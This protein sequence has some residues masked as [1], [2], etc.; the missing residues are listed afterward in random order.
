[1]QRPSRS[2][3][4]H[5][6]AG[7]PRSPPLAIPKNTPTFHYF[8]PFGGHVTPLPD[9]EPL[10]KLQRKRSRRRARRHDQSERRHQQF[11]IDTD[12]R[13]SNRRTDLKQLNSLISANHLQQITEL[14][15]VDFALQQWSHDFFGSEEDSFSHVDV[16]VVMSQDMISAIPDIV[17]PVVLP[18]DCLKV[19]S[20]CPAS[21][22]THQTHPVSIHR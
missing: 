6:K 8:I 7:R 9:E 18:P 3:C 21:A 14:S 1:M 16:Q 11:L 22:N 19:A 15:P 13:I 17:C 5:H 10:S 20:T 2:S 4:S 12:G